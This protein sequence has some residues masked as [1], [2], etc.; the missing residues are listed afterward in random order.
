MSRVMIRAKFV[1][2]S[3][4]YL[5]HLYTDPHIVLISPFPPLKC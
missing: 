1:N 2:K 3:A 4:R 5:G